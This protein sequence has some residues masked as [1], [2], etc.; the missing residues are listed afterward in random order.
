[1]LLNNAFEHSGC[2]VS[3]P[4]TIGIHERHRAS[5]ADLQAVG[6]GSVNAALA[7]QLEFLKPRFEEVPR[8]KAGIDITALGF[9][10]VAAKKNMPLD[11]VDTEA[12]QLFLQQAGFNRVGFGGVLFHAVF[13]LCRV[14]SDRPAP[15][16]IVMGGAG[17]SQGKIAPVSLDHI[18]E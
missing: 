18:T 6:L 5:H 17:E 3:I 4:D 7:G 11:I 14:G 15:L 8:F 13:R 10:L 9:A 1:M 2:A 16:I 12:S